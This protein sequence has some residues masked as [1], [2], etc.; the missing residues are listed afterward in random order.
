[1]YRPRLTIAA[2][3][4]PNSTG[5][6]TDRGALGRSL[7]VWPYRETLVGTGITCWFVFI[8]GEGAMTRRGREPVGSFWDFVRGICLLPAGSTNRSRDS[9]QHGPN[10]G[11]I[12]TWGMPV[13]GACSQYA[14][15]WLSWSFDGRVVVRLPGERHE[16]RTPV[17][18]DHVEQWER[19]PSTPQ[20]LPATVLMS[21][22]EINEAMCR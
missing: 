10:G 12:G 22:L 19:P 11:R 18:G 9:P 3:L 16:R 4:E 1:M 15:T 13:S 21:G 14:A 20:S 7:N 2:C 8:S 17:H 6:R 5:E